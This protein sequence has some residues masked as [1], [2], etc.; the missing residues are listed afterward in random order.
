MSP[1]VHEAEVA[2]INRHEGSLDCILE[3]SR[4]LLNLIHDGGD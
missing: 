2:A 3:C 1:K 4:V